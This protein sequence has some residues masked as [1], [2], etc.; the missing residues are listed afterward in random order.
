[1]KKRY[2]FIILGAVGI[3]CLMV[4]FSVLTMVVQNLLASKREQGS[5]WRLI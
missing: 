5:Q 1:M 2:I 3:I 4:W